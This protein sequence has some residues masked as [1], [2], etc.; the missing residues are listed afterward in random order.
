MLIAVVAIVEGDAEPGRAFEFKEGTSVIA[1]MLAGAALAFYAL[2]GFEDSVNVAEEVQQPQSHVSEG[3]LRRASRS[4]AS[5]TSWSPSAPPPSS[6]PA[7]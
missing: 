3:P 1:A 2:V 4:P 6:P 5:S 7:T